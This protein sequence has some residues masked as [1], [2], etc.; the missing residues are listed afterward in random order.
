MDAPA[1]AFGILCL[2]LGILLHKK[3][4]KLGKLNGPVLNRVI[5]ILMFLGGTGL[6]GTFIGEWLSGLNFSIGEVGLPP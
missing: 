3:R 2:A 6:A 4:A 1:I 5:S